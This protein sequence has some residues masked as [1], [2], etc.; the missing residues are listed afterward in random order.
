MPSATLALKKCRQKYA[1]GLVPNA[2]KRKAVMNSPNT[3]EEKAIRVEAVPSAEDR[4]RS[5]AAAGL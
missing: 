3:A 4:T 2:V 5:A 1:C